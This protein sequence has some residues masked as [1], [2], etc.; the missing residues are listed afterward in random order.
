MSHILQSLLYEDIAADQMKLKKDLDLLMSKIGEFTNSKDI[1]TFEGR[2]DPEKF[3]RWLKKVEHILILKDMPEGKMVKLVASRVQRNAST[4]WTNISTQ[5]KFEGK[6]KVQTWEKMRKLL[7]KRF[8]PRDYH[9]MVPSSP[10]KTHTSTIPL[11]PQKPHHEAPPK[12]PRA[13]TL[14][15]FPT[16]SIPPLTPTPQ[17]SI[18][19]QPL[20]S[21]SPA[22]MVS[23]H[24][25]TPLPQIPSK[26]TPPPSLTPT[27]DTSQFTPTPAV[28]QQPKT[29]PLPLL[30]TA[31]HTPNSCPTPP[32]QSLPKVV[33]LSLPQ[34]PKSTLGESSFFMVQTPTFAPQFSKS[35]LPYS[36]TTETM[37]PTTPKI[38]WDEYDDEDYNPIWDDELVK[39]KE[40]VFED[41]EDNPFWVT[42]MKEEDQEEKT[43]KEAVTPDAEISARDLSSLT[44]LCTKRVE[45][46]QVP[47]EE[48][49][50]ENCDSKWPI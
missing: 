25:P 46:L 13:S 4:W 24:S 35:D 34:T 45:F 8:L 30:T 28:R 49:I 14:R 17:A 3:L 11:S 10:F 33:S 15:M 42:E 48:K 7:I 1:P 38:I 6:P 18:E 2:N 36:Q 43:H 9:H 39:K 5:R 16:L 12:T 37:Q 47:Y 21:L 44:V 20:S 40:E 32:P 23:N 41:A 26:T 31:H 50:E 19:N 22:P 29:I 27:Q